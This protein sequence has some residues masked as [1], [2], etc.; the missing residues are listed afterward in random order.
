MSN[1]K[2]PQT[3]WFLEEEWAE[4]LGEEPRA[5]REKLKRHR[6]PRKRWGNRVLVS[7]EALYSHM[8]S[9]DDDAEKKG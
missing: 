4:A 6:V 3:G 9:E 1:G 5:F 7:A 8:P 2:L